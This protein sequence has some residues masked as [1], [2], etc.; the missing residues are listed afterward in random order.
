MI[1]IMTFE[2][3]LFKNLKTSKNKLMMKIPNKD[4]IL[5]QRQEIEQELL[6]LLKQTKSDFNLEDIK[7]IIYN[8]QDNDD[9]MQ[10]FAMFDRGGDMGEMSNIL[11]LIN[12]AWNYFPHKCLGGLCPM[13]KLL[14][15]QNNL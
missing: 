2:N 7:E 9:L 10:V 13:E 11:E 4:Q 3:F 12:D 14:E 15:N 5:K 6:E 8:E 1:L